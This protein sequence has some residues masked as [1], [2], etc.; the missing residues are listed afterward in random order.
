MYWPS[1][2]MTLTQCLIWLMLKSQIFCRKGVKYQDLRILQLSIHSAWTM[3][4]LH[5]LN[6]AHIPWMLLAPFEGDLIYRWH[7]IFSQC[8][9]H[10]DWIN[11]RFRRWSSWL[12]L[13]VKMVLI[14]L[15]PFFFLSIEQKNDFGIILTNINWKFVWWTNG[16]WKWRPICN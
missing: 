6:Q 5:I 3:I 12:L 1:F 7:F 4:K 13:E 14:F 11:I 10:L 2:K 16:P 8:C 15:G 9:T